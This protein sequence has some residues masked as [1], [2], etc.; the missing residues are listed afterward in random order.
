MPKLFLIKKF[1]LKYKLVQEIFPKE[2]EADLIVKTHSDKNV[3][4]MNYALI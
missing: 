2:K 1:L 3:N 4:Y